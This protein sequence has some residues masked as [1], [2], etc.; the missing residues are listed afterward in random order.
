[1]V[2]V[3]QLQQMFRREGNGHSLIVLASPARLTSAS[4]ISSYFL[5]LRAIFLEQNLSLVG[6]VLLGCTRAHV[7]Q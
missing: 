2:F 5:S 3:L 6:V 1:M 4:A 7:A